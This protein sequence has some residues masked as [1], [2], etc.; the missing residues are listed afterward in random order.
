MILI[1]DGDENT[2]SYD[3]EIPIHHA[4]KNNITI[5]LRILLN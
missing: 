1:S 4:V 3:L 2:Q 5:N